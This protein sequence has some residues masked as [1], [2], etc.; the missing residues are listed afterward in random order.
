MASTHRHLFEEFLRPLA[1]HETVTANH[2]SRNLQNV[3]QVEIFDGARSA[4]VATNH[5]FQAGDDASPHS[6]AFRGGVAGEILEA[7]TANLILATVIMPNDVGVLAFAIPTAMVTGSS[8]SAEDVLKSVGGVRRN[9]TE[10]VTRFSVLDDGGNRP[11]VQFR[12][13]AGY[14]DFDSLFV[15]G[16]LIVAGD[17]DHDFTQDGEA[18]GFRSQLC[19]TV[20]EFVE[21]GL[22][23]FQI[24][25]QD[26][27]DFRFLRRAH[28]FAHE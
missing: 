27:E 8:R 1:T 24:F 9:R 7:T 12:G 21:L 10:D 19:G 16:L 26:A 28:L 14:G 6:D 23:L 13:N 4:A 2:A 20:V 3:Q 15:A 11:T 5:V 18:D 17:V 22:E 25:R